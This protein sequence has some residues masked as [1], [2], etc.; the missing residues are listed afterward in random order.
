M[1]LP[2]PLEMLHGSWQALLMALL[3]GGW[4]ERLR[5]HAAR[6]CCRVALGYH[7]C[8]LGQS[9]KSLLSWDDCHVKGC[10]LSVML[11]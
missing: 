6:H 7:H 3:Q 8:Q 2:S 9:R 5:W 10:A 11:Y 1:C 4:P